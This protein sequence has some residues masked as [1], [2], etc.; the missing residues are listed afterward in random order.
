MAYFSN[1][2]EG[3]VLENQCC[4]CLLASGPCP[5]YIAQISYNYPAC[6]N[7]VARSI[8]N[9]IVSQEPDG[10]Y[11]GCQMKPLLDRYKK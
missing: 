3:E 11:I 1:S 8:L 2:S 10:T 6:N 5:I 4:D 7:Q 9:C